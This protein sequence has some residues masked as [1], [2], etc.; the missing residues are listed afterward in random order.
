MVFRVLIARGMCA[1]DAAAELG[2]P[3][4]TA[5][6]WAADPAH[7]DLVALAARE[8]DDGPSRRDEAIAQRM[9]DAL[10]RGEVRVSPSAVT[11][12]DAERLERSGQRLAETLA[13]RWG[14]TADAV[15]NRVPEYEPQ[16]DETKVESRYGQAFYFVLQLLTLSTRE[17]PD[18]QGV[19]AHP[20]YYDPNAYQKF[21]ALYTPRQEEI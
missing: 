16:P 4:R 1:S 19:P 21:R 12:A 3:G 18:Q 15:R 6:V 7:R 13:A 14:T 9:L 10:R 20:T 2:V 8:I 11:E 5:R 17:E